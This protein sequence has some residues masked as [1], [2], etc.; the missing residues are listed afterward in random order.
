[1]MIRWVGEMA[2]SAEI[3]RQVRRALPHLAPRQ[4]RE[5]AVAVNRIVET[6]NPDRIYVFGSQARG[7]AKPDSDT[8]ILSSS[9]RPTSQPI[10]SP[11]A[12]MP[13]WHRSGCRWSY[14][15]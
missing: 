14:S 7:T 3:E 10:A 9:R 5:L 2:V 12:P 13:H 6:F 8:D 11:R 1:M 15:S 4:S